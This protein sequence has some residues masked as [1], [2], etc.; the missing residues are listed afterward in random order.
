M[1][2]KI[3]DATNIL[4]I[5]TYSSKNIRANFVLTTYVTS[6]LFACSLWMYKCISMSCILCSDLTRAYL[7]LAF[8]IIVTLISGP[9]SFFSLHLLHVTFTSFIR[10][11]HSWLGSSTAEIVTTYRVRGSFWRLVAATVPYTM[12]LDRFQKSVCARGLSCQKCSRCSRVTLA[13]RSAY[14]ARKTS[15]Y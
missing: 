12:G 11:F 10:V 3:K 1:R 5:E 14:E 13:L 9:I 4:F 15:R 2:K 7:E 8:P 6:S